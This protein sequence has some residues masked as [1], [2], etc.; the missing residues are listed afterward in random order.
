MNS[1]K[2]VTK[3]KWKQ[4]YFHLRSQRDI[5]ENTK[6]ITLLF[7]AINVKTEGLGN[8]NEEDTIMNIKLYIVK[9]RGEWLKKPKQQAQKE[10]Y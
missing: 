10:C 2:F 9:K 4:N 7:L 1:P 3:S 6:E 5:K 8:Q